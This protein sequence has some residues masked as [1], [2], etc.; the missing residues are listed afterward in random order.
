MAYETRPGHLGGQPSA[1]RHAQQQYPATPNGTAS[2]TGL[3]GGARAGRATEP[4]RSPA[5]RGPR[6]S[7]Y[8]PP[9]AEHQDHG[10]P[11][12]RAR[13]APDAREAEYVAEPEPPT[14]LPRL[15]TATPDLI[16]KY[17]RSDVGRRLRAMNWKHT[18]HAW[19]LRNRD[20]LGPHGLALFFL[21]ID[22]TTNN[23]TN[24]DNDPVTYWLRTTTRLDPAGPDVAD[25][26]RR[27]HEFSDGVRRYLAEGLSVLDLMTR[28]EALTPHAL[29][30]GAGVSS[31]DT[32]TGPWDAV[33]HQVS[34][35]MD[36]PGRCYAMLIDGTAMIMDRGGLAQFVRVHVTCNAELADPSHEWSWERD[37]AVRD[38][39]AA[40]FDRLH[41][42]I[43]TLMVGPAA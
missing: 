19:N 10:G 28:V 22:P 9:A 33:R 21:D 32:P 12:P 6:S 16:N 7:A 42:L 34:H 11:V 4:S 3:P 37:L 31:L 39:G 8:G 38:D 17:V 40:V 20:P 18:S 2:A 36:I 1:P 27:V 13:T 25:L 23:D 5:D 26:P 41:H 29:L 15:P 24:E 35:P 43:R 14:N 30:L